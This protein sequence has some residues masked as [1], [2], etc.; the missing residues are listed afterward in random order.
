MEELELKEQARQCYIEMFRAMMAKDAVAL[1]E[2]LDD[3]FTL[4]HVNGV[5]STK[6]EYVRNIADGSLVFHSAEHESIIIKTD[7]NYATLTGK[8]QTDVTAGGE[9][10]MWHLQQDLSLVCK[11]GK[12]RIVEAQASTY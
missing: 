11:E 7:G 8:S 3:G 4:V 6:E 12:W 2:V 10:R 1:A 5:K 9:R